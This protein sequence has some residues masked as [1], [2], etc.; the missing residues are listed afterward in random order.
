MLRVECVDDRHPPSNSCK[1]TTLDMPESR[2]TEQIHWQA[3]QPSEVACFSED[4]KRCEAWDTTCGYKAKDLTPSI[5]WRR[6]AWKEEVLDDLPW[7][8]E[9]GPSSIRWTLEPFQRHCWG[10]WDRVAYIW[11]FLSAWTP[12][13]TEQI[14]FSCRQ[15]KHSNPPCVSNKAC[16]VPHGDG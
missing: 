7:K 2:T 8:N 11:A 16:T 10:N 3:K 1:W 6:E 13:W 14:M 4:L 5:T 12:S 9:R 15:Q